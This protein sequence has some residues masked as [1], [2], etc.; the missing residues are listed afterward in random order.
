MLL[1]TPDYQEFE[2]SS[3]IKYAGA[4]GIQEQTTSVILYAPTGLQ[5]KLKAHKLSQLLHKAFQTSIKAFQKEIKISE[6]NLVN[7]ELEKDKKESI[8]SEMVR[9][10]VLADIDSDLN[11]IFEA[12]ESVVHMGIIKIAQ[13][14]KILNAIQWREVSDDDKLNMMYEYLAVFI[15]PSLVS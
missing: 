9:I 10:M 14:S 7:N 15:F 3:P 5:M 6:K 11:S 8:T 2:L 1:Q 13:N 12:F 4:Q